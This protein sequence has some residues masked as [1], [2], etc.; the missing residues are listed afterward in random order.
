MTTKKENEP[1]YGCATLLLPLI[2]WWTLISHGI[3]RFKNTSMTETH[4]FLNLPK[5]FMLQEP[6]WGME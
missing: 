3:M 6:K 2:F 5:S 1:N 4:L